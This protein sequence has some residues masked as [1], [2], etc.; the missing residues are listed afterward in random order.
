MAFEAIREDR[1][2]TSTPVLPA[3]LGRPAIIAVFVCIAFGSVL[4]ILAAQ[5]DLWLDE[6]WTF[7][8]L[9]RIMSPTDVLF[10]LHY[11]N[12]HPL[13]TLFLYWIGDAGEQFLW[14]RLHSVVAGVW[15]IAVAV[16]IAARRGRAEAVFAAFLFA[17]SFILVH[18][19]SQARGYSMMIAAA[20]TAFYAAQ[21]YHDSRSWASAGVYAVAT[22]WALLSNLYYLQSLIA[23]SVWSGCL[24]LERG[25]RQGQGFGAISPIVRLHVVPTIVFG[26]VVQ[27]F[28]MQGLVGSQFF[29]DKYGIIFQ[30]ASLVFGGP[31]TGE[32]AENLLLVACAIAGLGIAALWRD[33]DREW[34]FY[35]LAIFGAPAVVLYVS[36]TQ[37]LFVRFFV[38]SQVFGLLLLAISLGRLW[39]LHWVGAL[40]A[41]A[42][43]LLISLGNASYIEALIERGRGQYFD[44]V[45]YM[46]SESIGSQSTTGSD[47]PFGTQMVVRWYERFLPGEEFFFVSEEDPRRAPLWYV[48]VG[49]PRPAEMTY[50]NHLY[51]KDREFLTSAFGF[52]WQLY[53]R[54]PMVDAVRRRSAPDSQAGQ[55]T[56]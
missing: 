20:L 4:R 25:L 7:E 26:F 33:T 9:P 34:L 44:A 12:N 19:A 18:H 24:L 42:V 39:R 48:R 36:E 22:A 43:A 11:A 17:G 53:R 21:R 27:V 14:Y 1:G 8:L 52:S 13:N 28:Y 10:E 56:R 16:L 30:A 29:T 15:S 41:S 23:V 47:Y 54:V 31:Q 35:A 6:I 49:H 40:V 2:P 5:T 50:A 32:I 45:R 37:S 3:H 46:A 55:P 38:M 51:D